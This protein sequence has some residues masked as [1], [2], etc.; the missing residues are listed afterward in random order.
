MRRAASG[1]HAVVTALGYKHA[2]LP[3]QGPASREL[4]QGLTDADLSAAA[5][6]Y[7]S[8][9]TLTLAGV[10]MLVSR[11][12]YSG[13]LGYELFKPTQKTRSGCAEADHKFVVSRG[14]R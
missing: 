1:R 6:A 13:E 3:V 5:M 2:Y 10:P 4:L 7:F 12:G 14:R 11:N 8:C 9:R